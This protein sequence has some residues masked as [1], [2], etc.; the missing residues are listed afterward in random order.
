MKSNTDIGKITENA[1]ENLLRDLAS[2]AN[3]EDK[4]SKTKEITEEKAM[5]DMINSFQKRVDTLKKLGKNAS[6]SVFDSGNEIDLHI[7]ISKA[8]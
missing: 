3:N 7:K 8:Q 2:T 5:N 1:I 4:R 6:I